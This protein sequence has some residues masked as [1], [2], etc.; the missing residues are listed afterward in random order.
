M[1]SI[2]DPS[3]NPSN[4]PETGAHLVLQRHHVSATAIGHWGDGPAQVVSGSNVTLAQCASY[5]LISK[6]FD[7]NQQLVQ[8]IR[9]YMPDIQ[10]ELD[11]NNLLQDLIQRVRE[12]NIEGAVDSEQLTRLLYSSLGIPV[13]IVPTDDVEMAGSQ[14]TTTL[15]APA[16]NFLKY[17]PTE[18]K[19]NAFGVLLRNLTIR[20]YYAARFL[21]EQRQFQLSCE[22]RK[23]A[24]NSITAIVR[25]RGIIPGFMPD[26]AAVELGVPT[27]V[28]LM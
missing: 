22:K 18:I 1:E 3:W 25:G 10:Q 13:N 8:H 9:Q 12:Q 4:V 2:D 24:V 19:K 11:N 20:N 16:E 14:S 28:H 15:M 6:R 7:V 23:P 26:D 5:G 27:G 17:T 21:M